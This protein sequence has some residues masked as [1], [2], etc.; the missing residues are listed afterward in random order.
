MSTDVRVNEQPLGAGTYSLWAEP[1]PDRWTIIF[2]K[3]HP[4]F[5]T[6]YPAG[7]DA[8]RVSVTPRQGAHMETLAFYF[9]VVDGRRGEL[10]LHWGTVVV[11]LQLDVP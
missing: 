7:Q 2:N 10:V 6:R 9:P 8:M 11:P 3:V 4:V 5:H 1:R